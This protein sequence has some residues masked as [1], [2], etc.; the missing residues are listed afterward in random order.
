MKVEIVGDKGLTFEVKL[1]AEELRHIKEDFQINLGPI[2]S[3]CGKFTTA[4]LLETISKV[5]QFR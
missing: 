1:N 3:A 5:L 4:E 2:K